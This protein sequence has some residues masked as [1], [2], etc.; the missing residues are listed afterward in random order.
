MG[1]CDKCRKAL[2]ESPKP[3]CCIKDFK[4]QHREEIIMG[5]NTESP[6][7]SNSLEKVNSKQEMKGRTTTLYK[8]TRAY[9]WL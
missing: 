6:Q 4:T 8:N 3:K 1:E 5:V 2:N 9:F 7:E